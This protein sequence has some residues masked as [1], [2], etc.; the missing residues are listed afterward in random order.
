MK[1]D[2]EIRF[3]LGSVLLDFQSFTEKRVIECAF[4]HPMILFSSYMYLVNNSMDRVSVICKLGMR[5]YLMPTVHQLTV[6]L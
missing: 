5:W 6:S 3:N 1:V 4:A 2:L